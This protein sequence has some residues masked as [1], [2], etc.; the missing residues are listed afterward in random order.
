[1]QAQRPRQA[2]D[3]S[4][5]VVSKEMQKYPSDVGLL[6]CVYIVLFCLE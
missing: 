2:P 6:E 4:M 3:R 1:M 5:R